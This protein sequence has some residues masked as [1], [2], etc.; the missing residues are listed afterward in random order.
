MKDQQKKPANE[1]EHR[2][3]FQERLQKEKLI[4]PGN[5]HSHLG[6]EKNENSQHNQSHGSSNK[7]NDA[8]SG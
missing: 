4:D 7:N 1:Q 2:E 8:H 3:A 5:E 6:D